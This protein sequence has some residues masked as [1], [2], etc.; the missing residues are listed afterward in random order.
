MSRIKADKKFDC[1]KFKDAAQAQVY[2]EI[3]GLT[4]QQQIEYFNTNAESGPLADWW[5]NIRRHRA[6]RGTVKPPKSA[7]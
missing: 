7:R 1:V 4:L 2:K 6:A 3:K 5:K